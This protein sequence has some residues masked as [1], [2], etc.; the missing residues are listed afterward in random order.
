MEKE[1]RSTLKGLALAFLIILG[2][3]LLGIGIS[4][5]NGSK[6]RTND[7]RESGVI[8]TEATYPP[9]HPA[10]SF[11]DSEINRVDSILKTSKS[12]EDLIKK[13]NTPEEAAIIASSLPHPHKGGD[14]TNDGQLSF[15]MI[16]ER[17]W[18][19]CRS[20]T[21][22]MAN[23]LKDNGYPPKALFMSPKEFGRGCLGHVVFIYEKDGKFGSGGI[24]SFDIRPPVYN[25][26]DDLA[27]DIAGEISEK[28]PFY[29][30]INY[31]VDDL[32]ELFQ[33]FD[34]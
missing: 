5:V 9:S 21:I 15:S 32:E 30:E 19:D 7:I 26:I 8:K 27:K 18:G 4:K 23:L 2:P 33:N 31:W 22:V 11:P 14:M 24:N 28:F 13:I 12:K 16:Y 1:T 3:S 25:T 17:G 29:R 10:Y 34:K 20:G 6:R